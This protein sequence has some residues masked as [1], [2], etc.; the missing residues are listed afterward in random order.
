MTLIVSRNSSSLGLAGSSLSCC[1]A[2]VLTLAALTWSA[3]VDQNHDKLTAHVAALSSCLSGVSMHTCRCARALGSS[4]HEHMWGF[5]EQQS[6]RGVP[7]CC[8]R[9]RPSR[10][11]RWSSTYTPSKR[12]TITP[13]SRRHTFKTAPAAAAESSAAYPASSVRSLCDTH[14]RAILQAVGGAKD[15]FCTVHVD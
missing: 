5:T 4:H 6:D 12:C 11:T 9:T 13:T 10:S 7:R 15:T 1:F 8:R 14:C 2:T 3:R